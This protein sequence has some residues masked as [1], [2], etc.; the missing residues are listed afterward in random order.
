MIFGNLKYVNEYRNKR[1]GE[2]ERQR[3]IEF[4]E[5]RRSYGPGFSHIGTAFMLINYLQDNNKQT[6]RR[7][8]NEND[9]IRNDLLRLF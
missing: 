2:K 3:E 6:V 4:E 9:G 1:E 5:N 8:Q 7:P